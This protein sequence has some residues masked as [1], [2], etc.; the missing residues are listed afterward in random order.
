[1]GGVEGGL[2]RKGMR[3]LCDERGLVLILAMMALLLMSALGAAVI[4][5]T[6]SE[7][8]I[9]G[10]YRNSIEALYAADAIAERAVAELGGISDWDAVLN[11]LVRSSIVDGLPGGLR[12]LPAG[13][14]LDL[15]RVL[16]L[17]NCGKITTCS[18]GDI[19]GNATGNR[20]WGADNPVWRLF[21]Y[22]P[23]GEVLPTGGSPF[24]VLAMVADDPSERDGDPARDGSGEGNPGAGIISVRAEAFGPRGTHKI[25][26]LTVGRSSEGQDRQEG[27][28]GQEGQNGQN[29]QEGQVGNRM[30]RARVLSWRE[31]R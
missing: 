31:I 20:P 16:S 8:V 2:G 19:V 11:E 18:A 26:E 5:T 21:T 28:E 9:A 23:L 1:M 24:Y 13:G 7:S 30:T 25:I 17:A 10:N 22:G 4:L 3:G 6:S 12:A 29:G 14:T 15:T 27:Q